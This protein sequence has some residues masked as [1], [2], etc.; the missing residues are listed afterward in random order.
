MRRGKSRWSRLADRI[1]SHVDGGDLPH[2]IACSL[3][4]GTRQGQSQVRS[5][6]SEWQLMGLQIPPDCDAAIAAATMAFGAAVLNPRC[7]RKPI[8]LPTRR[9]YLLA[10]AAAQSLTSLYVTQVTYL[11][12]PADRAFRTRGSGYG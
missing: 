2:R 9:C 5:Q 1:V 6:A 10:Y 8:R 3:K 4:T 7:R 12:Q 11:S